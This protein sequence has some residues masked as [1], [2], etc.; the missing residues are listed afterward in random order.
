MTVKLA[1]FKS[2]EQ[3]ISDI[4][5]ILSPENKV[6]GYL[7]NNPLTVYEEEENPQILLEEPET[8][9]QNSVQI[10]MSRWI[11]LSKNKEI[12]IP[13]DWV[14]TIVDPIDSLI[15]MYNSS[16]KENDSMPTSEEPGP[17]I[18]LQG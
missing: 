2:G 11:R 16:L 9:G 17:S 8:D 12:M 6:I 18:D 5:E 3:I 14:V 13:M 15:E 1:I 4:K 7:L 10:V